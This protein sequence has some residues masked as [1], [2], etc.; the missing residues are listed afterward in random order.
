MSAKYANYAK[1]A[2]FF[3]LRKTAKFFLGHLADLATFAHY[4]FGLLISVYSKF[5]Q[6]NR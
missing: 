5:V 3:A 1:Y 6:V 2:K 4:C